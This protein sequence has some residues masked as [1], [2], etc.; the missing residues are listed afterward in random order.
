MRYHA[1][2]C[3]RKLRDLFHLRTSRRFLPLFLRW[4]GS[5]NGCVQAVMEIIKGILGPRFLLQFFPG[6]HFSRS[7]KKRRQ[8]LQGLLLELYFLPPR[9]QFHSLEIDRER[10]E[11][12]N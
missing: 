7:F 5:D 11:A 12:N 6:N 1:R 2:D 4:D 9:A 3:P 8:D 10:T